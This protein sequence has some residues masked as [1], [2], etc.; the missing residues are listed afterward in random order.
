MVGPIFFVIES[1]EPM[2]NSVL[3]KNWIVSKWVGKKQT[4][5]YLFWVVKPNTIV[6]G[7]L[8]SFF[9]YVFQFEVAFKILNTS[10]SKFAFNLWN[11]MVFYFNRFM[12][13]STF[14]FFAI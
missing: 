14:I 1:Q 2:Q 7:Q 9:L 6:R 5:E 4:L 8:W 12:P 11:E 13:N 10:L 3:Q